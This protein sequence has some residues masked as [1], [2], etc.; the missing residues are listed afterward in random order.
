MFLPLTLV[1]RLSSLAL[2]VKEGGTG[3]DGRPAGPP[4]A[5]DAL[6]RNGILAVNGPIPGEEGITLGEGGGGRTDGNAV[7]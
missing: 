6:L 7:D 1:R 3:G 5:Y 2:I 4:V